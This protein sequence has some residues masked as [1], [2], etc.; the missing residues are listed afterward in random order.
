MSKGKRIIFITKLGSYV[1]IGNE[2][3]FMRFN[4]DGR[5]LGKFVFAKGWNAFGEGDSLEMGRYLRNLLYAAAHSFK[6]IELYGSNFK[7]CGLARK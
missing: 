4:G 5:S 7:R 3:Y 1:N 2:E 6:G